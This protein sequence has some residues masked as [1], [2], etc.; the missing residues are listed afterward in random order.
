MLVKSRTFVKSR[1]LVK[2]RSFVKSRMLAKSR[3]LV[4]FPTLVKSRMLVKSPKLIKFPSAKLKKI[5]NYRK[6][7][8]A[9][10]LKSQMLA[11]YREPVQYRDLI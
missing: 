11:K 2:S 8:Y 5:A 6:R 7:A 3:M 1:M 10:R 9:T 4:K